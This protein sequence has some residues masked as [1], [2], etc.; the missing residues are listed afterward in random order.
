MITTIDNTGLSHRH[1]KKPVQDGEVRTT[2][3][4]STV[5][6]VQG[7]VSMTLWAASA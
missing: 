7:E 4:V 6:V 5:R 1:V 3:L 2:P